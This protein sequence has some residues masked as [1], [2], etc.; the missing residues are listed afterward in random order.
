MA[1]LMAVMEMCD[2]KSSIPKDFCDAA[3]FITETFLRE[4]VM[5]K[6]ILR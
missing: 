6:I 4:D 2:K 5:T 1:R 3:A